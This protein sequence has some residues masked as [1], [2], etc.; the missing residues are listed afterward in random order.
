MASPA[1]KPRWLEPVRLLDCKIKSEVSA[2][3]SAPAQ[4]RV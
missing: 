2:P 3:A 1:S 4:R